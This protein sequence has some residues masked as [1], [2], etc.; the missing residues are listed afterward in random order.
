MK[1]EK[2]KQRREMLTGE[3]K[4]LYTHEPIQNTG[5]KLTNDFYSEA[6]NGYF[7]VTF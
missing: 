7:L 1:R 2:E 6:M 3:N 5:R 4:S